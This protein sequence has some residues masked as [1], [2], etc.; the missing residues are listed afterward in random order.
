MTRAD[1]A[2]ALL[3]QASLAMETQAWI[4]RLAGDARSA[5]AVE[6]RAD[7]LWGRA[8]AARASRTRGD[9]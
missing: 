6:A 2:Y 5:D 4:R 7:D 1:V 9:A 3:A 8:E